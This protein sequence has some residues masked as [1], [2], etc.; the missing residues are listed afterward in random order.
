MRYFGRENRVVLHVQ[1]YEACVQFYRDGL[2]LEPYGGWDYGPEDH[3]LKFKN[4]GMD[5]EV[6]E[7]E[8]PVPQGP[9][10][11][12]MEAVDLDACYAAMC[13]KPYM[14]ERIIE[15]PTDRPYG[16]RVFR[17]LD[18]GGNDVVIYSNNDLALR[19]PAVFRVQLLTD[20]YDEL[21]AFY[22]KVLEFPVLVKRETV[23]GERVRVY[24][25][26]GGEI[27]LIEQAGA[28]AFCADGL[29]VQVEVKDVDAYWEKL[30][31]AGADVPNGPEDRFYGHRDFQVKDPQGLTLKFF[32]PLKL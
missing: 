11:I 20:C 13:N 14:R 15:P 7:R 31:A 29:L 16:I 2:E 6:I 17:M 5:V 4:P 32:T 3:G 22:G 24:G 30:R 12:M 23:P 18:P 8:P 19:S 21:C 28:E 27:E 9:T 1:A 10:T 25:A 26:A